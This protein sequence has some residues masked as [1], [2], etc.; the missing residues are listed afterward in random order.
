MFDKTGLKA[1]LFSA[2][3]VLA[4][5]A[6]VTGI[7]G[8][9]YTEDVGGLGTEIGGELAPLGDAAT[10]I[11]LACQNANHTLDQIISGKSGHDINKVWAQLDDAL[12]YCDLIERGGSG[13]H[14]ILVASTDPQVLSKT[15]K[16]RNSLKRFDQSARK[17]YSQAQTSSDLSVGNNRKSDNAYDKLQRGLDQILASYTSDGRNPDIANLV[18]DAKYL[19]ADAQI[20]SDRLDAS[21]GSNAIEDVNARYRTV[22]STIYEIGALTGSSETSPLLD[23]IEELT[24]NAGRQFKRGHRS[25]TDGQD[26]DRRYQENYEQLVAAAN[27]IRTFIRSSI[28]VRTAR[29]EDQT[30]TA[31]NILLALVGLSLLI[32]ILLGLRTTRG[33]LRPVA[34]VQDAAEQVTHE[35][36]DFARIATAISENDL[37]SKIHLTRIKPLTVGHN[38]EI[39]SLAKAINGTADAGFQ[40]GEAMSKMVSNLENMVRQIDNGSVDISSAATEIAAQSEQTAMGVKTQTEQIDQVSAA[41]EQMAANVVESTRNAGEASSA[42]SEASGTAAEG[43]RVVNDAIEGMQRIADVVRT[44]SETIGKLANSAEEI[45]AITGV[46][47]EIADQTNLLALNAAIEAARAG[48]QGRGFAVVADEVRKLAERTGKA[49]G[50]ITGMIKNIQGSTDEAVKSMESGITEVDAGRELTDKAGASLTEIAGIT[51]RVTDIIRQMTTSSEQQS[52]A[53][54]NI[55][56]NIEQISGVSN[57]TSAG[58]AESASA[59][60]ALN[61]SAENL[62]RLVSEFK[63]NQAPGRDQI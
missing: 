55:A 35:L 41:V 36:L 21:D 27:D 2:F 29:L 33:V 34:T 45:N 30:A 31:F 9:Y 8:I 25:P 48:E 47:N 22:R 14:G 18:T 51:D 23:L 42:A 37:R 46:I 57:E 63:V 26:V 3:I 15:R 44:S 10:E 11:K 6:G 62:K 50:E 59:T 24:D 1:R 49:T 28:S 40:I 60:D 5:M 52:E 12:S 54:E 7:A 39:A 19:C 16:A 53:A 17:R 4:A 61:R 13:K 20:W 58:A 32:A 43:G 56:R 38:D